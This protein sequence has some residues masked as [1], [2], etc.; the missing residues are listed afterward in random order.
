MRDVKFALK[1]ITTLGIDNITDENSNSVFMYQSVKIRDIY[2]QKGGTFVSIEIAPFRLKKDKPLNIRWE[3]TKRMIHGGL[4]I[5]CTKDMSTIHFATV[6]EKPEAFEM[7][8]SYK[9]TGYVNISV[10]MKPESRGDF[11]YETYLKLSELSKDLILIEARN[12]FEAYQ[13]FLTRLKEMP[14]NLPFSSFKNRWKP[15]SR[16]M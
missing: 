10:Q 5:F 9:K 6:A 4:V 3:N 2:F 15:R 16:N 14:R 13:H 8:K 1:N 12:Y 11:T 7:N